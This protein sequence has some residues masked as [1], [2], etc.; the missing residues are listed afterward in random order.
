MTKEVSCVCKYWKIIIKGNLVNLISDP[1]KKRKV[2]PSKE[3]NLKLISELKSRRTES[4]RDVIRITES[5]YG[6]SNGDTYNKILKWKKPIVP[7]SWENDEKYNS[8]K[9]SNIMKVSNTMHKNYNGS[10]SKEDLSVRRV[11][12]S[13][14]VEDGRKTNNVVVR[15]S[16]KN[17]GTYQST[18]GFDNNKNSKN[19][20]DNKNG[21]GDN[22]SE[23]V[24]NSDAHLTGNASL[25][26]I[27]NKNVEESVH[28]NFE[29]KHSNH[30]GYNGKKRY[31][32]EK[33]DDEGIEYEGDYENEEEEEEDSPRITIRSRGN[34]QNGKN[35][36]GN[37]NVNGENDILSKYGIRE[38]DGEMK[39]IMLDDDDDDEKS[40]V[41]KVNSPTLIGSDNIVNRE[42]SS[43]VSTVSATT[44][45]SVI[46]E[47]EI[48]EKNESQS[49]KDTLTKKSEEMEKIESEKK[50]EKKNGN[51]EGTEKKSVD[52]NVEKKY[53][54]LLTHVK[55]IRS[56]KQLTDLIEFIQDGYTA[57]EQADNDKRKLKRKIKGTRSLLSHI[58][59]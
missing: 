54:H 10:N 58:Y 29:K 6:N 41:L 32:E 5:D 27:E 43:T 57:I 51:D 16:T 52:E 4:S 11:Q 21:N 25:D 38:E 56:E 9:S 50:N 36:H 46:K 30:R 3:N 34:K 17:S 37:G 49:D 48:I 53:D 39:Q 13:N 19:D 47:G 24:K 15:G 42:D 31:S 2:L 12:W 7:K 8:I 26:S 18:N 33:Y 40:A 35:G 45:S 28:N 59:P 55:D 23:V 20:D 1:E 14:S 44:D 22:N